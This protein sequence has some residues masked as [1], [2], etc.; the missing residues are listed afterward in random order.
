MVDTCV[1]TRVTG[2]SMNPTTKVVT[3]VTSTIYSGP[4]RVQE[5]LAF[6]RDSSP[7]PVDPALMRYRTLQLPVE[8]SENIRRADLV[9]IT[10][11]VHD[12]DLVGKAMFVRD[13][14]GK[15]EATSRRIGIEEVT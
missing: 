7:T 5:L 4:C 14:S 6:A 9:T 13:L 10:A 8:S 12:P 15:T 1:I 3:K 11:C 2:D